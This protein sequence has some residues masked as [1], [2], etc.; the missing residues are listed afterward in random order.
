MT[1]LRTDE[2]PCCGGPNVEGK[3]V[4]ITEE[5]ATQACWC[6]DCDAFWDDHFKL[7]EQ[8]VSNDIKSIRGLIYRIV[9][10]LDA[11]VHKVEEDANGDRYTYWR[12]LEKEGV[13]R[14]LDT[15]RTEV[16]K[17]RKEGRDLFE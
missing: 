12:F 5:G 7:Q 14:L 10:R 4:V 6:N 9:G 11:G 8:Q 3:G 17:K 2:C 16:M 13:L 15:L 1:E